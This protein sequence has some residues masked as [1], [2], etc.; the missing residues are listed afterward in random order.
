MLHAR[1]KDKFQ[2]T[3]PRAIRERAKIKA[4]DIVDFE[5]DDSGAITMRVKRLI[6]RHLAE[7]FEDYKK[8]RVYGPFDT[9][10]ELAKSLKKTA[11]RSRSRSR[12]R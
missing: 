12:S 1:V 11:R 6:D 10:D 2:I 9:A 8:G 3:L 7:S 5:V 4:G